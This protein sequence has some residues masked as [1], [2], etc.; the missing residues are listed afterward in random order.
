[1]V[2]VKVAVCPCF[3]IGVAFPVQASA[4][5]VALAR[6]FAQSLKLW[7]A[8][9]M[10]VTLKVI[11]PAGTIEVFD[12]LKASSE[13]L[14]AVTV[15]TL[16]LGLAAGFTAAERLT[17]A[18]ADPPVPRAA[19]SPTATQTPRAGT[20]NRK[21]RRLMWFSSLPSGTTSD[22]GRRLRSARPSRVPR[23]NPNRPPRRARHGEAGF[24]PIGRALA[25]ADHRRLCR[26]L[27]VRDLDRELTRLCIRRHP[28][29][30]EVVRGDRVRGGL[31]ADL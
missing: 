25:G 7:N 13:G 20:V 31:A 10:F 19:S 23:S 28:H 4:T 14:P 11:V 12:S 21:R 2:S 16:T 6:G 24:K 26:P 27:G 15:M 29:V 5:S 30:H 17:A 22:E 3:R 8:T 1:M 9:P 18:G